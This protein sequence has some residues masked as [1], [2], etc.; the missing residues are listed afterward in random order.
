MTLDLKSGDEIVAARFE[1]LE[2]GFVEVA[3]GERYR[4]PVGEIQVA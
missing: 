1:F 2:H 3:G 4:P